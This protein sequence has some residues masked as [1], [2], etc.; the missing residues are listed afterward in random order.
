M[1]RVISVQFTLEDL[2][3]GFVLCLRVMRLCPN[4]APIFEALSHGRGA[5]VIKYLLANGEA[6]PFDLDRDGN[7][8]LHV[9]S[10]DLIPQANS[11]Q[12]TG[13]LEEYAA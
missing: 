5:R 1:H 9:R 6:S 10:T 13:R 8:P 11:H 2:S 7:T 3:E 4:D 12:N